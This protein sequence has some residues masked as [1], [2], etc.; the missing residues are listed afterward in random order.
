MRADRTRSE[1]GVL[2]VLEGG[3]MEWW[4]V[5]F[6]VIPCVILVWIFSDEE[7]TKTFFDEEW[8]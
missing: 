6:I 3:M 5:L 7:K 8:P 4:E 2:S 1:P